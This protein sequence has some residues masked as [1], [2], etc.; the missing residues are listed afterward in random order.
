MVLME[1]LKGVPQ[2]LDYHPEGDV[3]THTGIVYSRILQHHLNDPTLLAASI[4]HDIGK[5]ETTTFNKDKGYY[6]SE[7]VDM[8]GELIGI[9]VCIPVRR[10]N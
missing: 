8:Y 5:L 9:S 2:R 3:C 10:Q 1:K 7:E 6:T 4:F